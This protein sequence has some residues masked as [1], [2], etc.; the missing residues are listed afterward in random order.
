MIGNN[1]KYFDSFVGTIPKEINKFIVNQTIITNVY[2]TQAFD[3]IMCGYFVLH[4]W[5]HIYR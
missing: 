2:G 5:F 3:S 4:Y 1:V